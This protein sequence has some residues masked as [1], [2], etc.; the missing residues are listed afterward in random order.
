MISRSEYGKAHFKQSFFGCN[1]AEMTKKT[2]EMIGYCHTHP[3]QLAQSLRAAMQNSAAS[4]QRPEFIE[5]YLLDP[6]MVSA[7]QEIFSRLRHLTI[8]DCAQFNLAWACSAPQNPFPELDAESDLEFAVPCTR[9]R[10]L[11]A[12][13]AMSSPY[14]KCSG[15]VVCHTIDRSM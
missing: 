7:L 10:G 1:D 11:E 2:V 3:Q 14:A 13:A 12:Y 5:C 8:H 15:D 4:N 9:N 6:A